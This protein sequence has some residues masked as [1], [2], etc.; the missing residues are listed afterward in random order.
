MAKATGRLIRAVGKRV[1]VEDPPDLQNLIVLDREM[2]KAWSVAID[3]LRYSG[4]TDREIGRELG[5]TRQ[6]IEQRWP[7]SPRR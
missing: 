7:R 4:F 6:A 5:M 1:A 2:K 3:G